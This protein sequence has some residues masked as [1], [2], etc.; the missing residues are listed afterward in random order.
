[1]MNTE[2]HSPGGTA[3]PAESSVRSGR[4]PGP[5]AWLLMVDAEARMV[6]RDTAGLVIPLGLPLLIMV[7]SGSAAAG[8]SVGGGLT[9]M[10]VYVM[11]LVLVLVIA[12]VAVINMP[13]FLA[14]YR[15]FRI[16]R[17]LAVTP[18]SPMM[19]LVAQFVVSALQILLGL[20]LAVGVAM[21]FFDASLPTHLLTALAVLLLVFAAMYAVGLVI[22]ALAPTT[23]SAVAIGLV[24][25]FGMGALGGLFGGM[26]NLPDTLADIGAWLPFG[27]GVEGLQAAWLGE[28]VD[29]QHWFSLG[30]TAVVGTGI[31]TA[32]FRWD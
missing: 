25:F 12:T 27:A 32:T 23:N 28:N 4:R 19:V 8:E 17:R 1:M 6:V 26:A 10:D 15:K 2:T 30:V 24:L 9:A 31:A 3:A 18:A 20:A 5:L 16:L 29:W 11:P 22:A 21:I 14:S 13:S 7:M